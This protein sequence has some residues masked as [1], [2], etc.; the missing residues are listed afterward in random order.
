MVARLALVSV[1]EEFDFAEPLLGFGESFVGTAHVAAQARNYL[2]AALDLLDH[3]AP[4]FD[5]IVA[6]WESMSMGR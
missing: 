4:P 3:G 5:F 1:F 2:I 6:R